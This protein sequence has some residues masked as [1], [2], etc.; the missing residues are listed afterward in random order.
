MKKK[1][2]PICI[3]AI[4]L[5]IGCIMLIIT[6][7]S[8]QDMVETDLP[9]D[10]FNLTDDDVGRHL[11]YSG[12]IDVLPAGEDEDS[13]FYAATFYEVYGSEDSD[14]V[15]IGMDV[16]KSMASDFE[17]V[18]ANADIKCTFRKCDEAMSEKFKKAIGD[19]I[20]YIY[21]LMETEIPENE[22][23]N[24]Q[25]I[26][27]PY[28]IEVDETPDYRMFRYIAPVL[29]AAAVIV[30][31]F[32]LFGKKLLYVAGAALAVAVVALVIT[33]I[34]K[35]KTMS[36]VEKAADGLYTMEYLHDYNCD[37]YLSA[38]I[39]SIDEALD[40]V[41]KEQLY[42]LPITFDPENFGCSA[43]SAKTPEGDCLFGRNFDY[44]STD[45]L[46]VHTSPENGYD[47]YTTVDLDFFGI[48]GENSIGS[49][50]AAAKFIMLLAP[51]ISMDGFNEKGLGVGSL[52]LGGIDEVHQDNGKPD[53]LF[54]SSIR[55]ILDKCATVDEA[56]E[57][58]GS[59]DIHTELGN[60]YHLFITDLSGKSVVVEWLGNE[61]I[62]TES[63]LVTNFMLC[64]N[65]YTWEECRRFNTI[66]SRLTET[67]GVLTADEAMQLLSDAAYNGKKTKSEW[68]CVYNLSDY[69]VDIC[70]DE[71][72]DRV[73]SFKGR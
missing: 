34:P 54:F 5:I 49:D 38:D 46:L 52:E 29:I 21:G 10:L 26:L 37:G 69:S 3:S 51:Y 15:S 2:I 61:M 23:E 19:Y 65:D 44:Y 68:S 70:L 48:G 39:S 60:S 42:N 24:G 41:L 40:W 73:Y 71:N 13:L 35:L 57:F 58:L 64:E 22:I 8:E 16:P 12:P 31:L 47:S 63:S 55:G 32:M 30:L 62:V 53:M 66:N 27:S 67:N 59:Y 56:I 7:P 17:K 43:F 20:I 14:F 11:Y 72:Y 1:I 50:S 28:Y 36:K 9:V 4:M 6:H 33:L 18:P 25:A 45:T